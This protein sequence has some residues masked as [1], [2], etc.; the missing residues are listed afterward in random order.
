M[1][2]QEAFSKARKLFGKNFFAECD[3]DTKNNKKHNKIQQL[4]RFY[5]GSCPTKPGVYKGYVGYSWEQ[6]FE[7]A[8]TDAASHKG[9]K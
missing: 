7:L 2:N 3:K 1:N 5:I 4:G 6:V 9:K 8:I